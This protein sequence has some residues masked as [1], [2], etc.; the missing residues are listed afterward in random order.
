MSGRVIYLIR[1][2]F[3]FGV[4]SANR[5]T[6]LHEV[7]QSLHSIGMKNSYAILTRNKYNNFKSG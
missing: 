2:L 1:L 3:I 4:K 7:T 6:S 5:R